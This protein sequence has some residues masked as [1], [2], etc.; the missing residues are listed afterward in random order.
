MLFHKIKTQ[1]GIIDCCFFSPILL[2]ILNVNTYFLILNLRIFPTKLTKTTGITCFGV[3]KKTTSFYWSDVYV[4]TNW[5]KISVL[6]SDSFIFETAA[7]GFLAT[8]LYGCL[9]QWTAGT[10]WYKL[11]IGYYQTRSGWLCCN[12]WAVTYLRLA[13]FGEK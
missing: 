11:V 13:A 7:P 3:M 2:V 5:H 10:V 8:Q 9:G 6:T 1:T 12:I 4:I